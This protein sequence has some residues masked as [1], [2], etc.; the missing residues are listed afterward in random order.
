[1]LARQAHLPSLFSIPKHI[2]FEYE[3]FPVGMAFLAITLEAKSD[4]D[5]SWDSRRKKKQKTQQRPLE[6][7]RRKTAAKLEAK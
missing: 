3:L 6:R 5:Q 4:F 7:L 1:M 2:F